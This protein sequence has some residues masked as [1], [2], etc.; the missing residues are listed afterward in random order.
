[1]WLQVV[2]KFTKKLH[3]WR[4]IPLSLPSPVSEECLP[5]RHLLLGQ[6]VSGSLAQE[7]LSGSEAGTHTK[8]PAMLCWKCSCSPIDHLDCCLTP[9]V[10][11]EE[12]PAFSAAARSLSLSNSF[13]VEF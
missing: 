12:F 9:Q 6:H 1:M 10:G 4:Q 11:Q 7:T 5:P 2:I 3:L 13:K 8:F